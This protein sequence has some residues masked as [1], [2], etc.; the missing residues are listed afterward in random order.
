MKKEIFLTIK[1]PCSRRHATAY[2][3]TAKVLIFK[4][5]QRQWFSFHFNANIQISQVSHDL[6]PVARTD[7]QGYPRSMIC[8]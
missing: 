6:A 7:I 1:T 3:I 4:V 2:T 5:N 8:R